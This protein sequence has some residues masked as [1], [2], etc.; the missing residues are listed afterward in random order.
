MQRFALPSLALSTALIASGGC[1]YNPTVE[2]DTDALELARG[3]S[4]D[5]LVSIDGE[6]VTGLEGL[7][8][9]VDDPSVATVTPSY[10]GR[11]LRIGG[12]LEGE[13]VVHI[14]SYGQDLPIPTRVGPPGI[15]S[16][17]TEPATISTSVG[18]LVEV[19]AKALDT[20]AHVVDITFES[21]WAVRDESVASLEANGM[22]LHAMGE[23]TTTLHVTHGNDSRVGP[24]S[25]FK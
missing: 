25:I 18:N 20:L 16:V 22:M 7:Y 8:W 4:S 13:T 10:D 12:D 23:G 21:R 6:E 17:W 5:V 15:V 9:T 19:R 11:H 2:V 3:T 24:V 14:S 1:L